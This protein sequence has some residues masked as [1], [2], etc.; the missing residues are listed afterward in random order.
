M[1]NDFSNQVVKNIFSYETMSP[2]QL[3]FQNKNQMIKK[4]IAIQA[5]MLKST[6]FA[7]NL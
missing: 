5:K 3:I 2:E 7:N 1:V 6:V 4:C